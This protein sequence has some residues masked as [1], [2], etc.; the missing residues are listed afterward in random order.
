MVEIDPATL[1]KWQRCVDLMAKIV[2]VPAGL[3]MRLD[4]D[5]IEVFAS[6]R[7]AGNPYEPGAREHFWNSGLY[8]ETVVNRGER[9]LVPDA[10]V[11]PDWDSNPD[12]KL[13]MISYL[14]FPIMSSTGVPFGTICV[15]DNKPNS[16]SEEYSN[17]VAEFRDII[18]AQLA[19]LDA[20]AELVRMNGEI[21][22][23]GKEIANLNREKDRFFSV[24][25]HDLKNLFTAVLGRSEM[26][27]RLSGRLEPSKVAEW[28]REIHQAGRNVFG[29][30]ENL[31]EWSRLQMD[32]I[33]IEPEQTD[34]RALIEES[35]VLLFPVAEAKR[36]TIDVGREESMVIDADRHVVG[37]VI[38][39]L[40][41]NA[42]KF[43]E[44]G[45]HV[46]VAI[47]K[48][49]RRCEIRVTDSGIGIPPETVKRI[50]RTE[51]MVS[52]PGT[53]GESGTGL[54]LLL[55]HELLRKS[56]GTLTVESE[57][58]VGSTFR[59]F[60]PLAG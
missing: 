55:C 3:I 49:D 5:D 31:L 50:C 57:T 56:G 11:D 35:L 58:G 17:L 47:R 45:G 13:D 38:R 52:T 20:N 33:R 27:A 18:Q 9:L 6:S 1:G 10:R 42:V 37:V 41:N 14:G 40:V 43:T 59:F 15:L 32:H 39:N 46:G 54:G 16:Y 25:A 22:R 8:C 28:S 23:Q 36:I 2:G 44:P 12:I 24:I 4:G 30:L 21:L 19:L 34:I 60:V 7:T 51:D 26:L 48:V 53:G 29:L